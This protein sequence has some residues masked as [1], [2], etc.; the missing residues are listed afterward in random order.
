MTLRNE[1]GVLIY[2]RHTVQVR[3]KAPLE[4]YISFP[5]QKQNNSTRTHKKKR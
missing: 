2:V 4:T 1:M 5:P 3:T